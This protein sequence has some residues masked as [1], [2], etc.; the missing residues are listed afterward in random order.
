MQMHIYKSLI[1]PIKAFGADQWPTVTRQIQ[2]FLS[3]SL[4]TGLKL[5]E[6]KRYKTM[7]IKD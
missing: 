2:N 6:V 3:E 4:L 5:P 7:T 1:S